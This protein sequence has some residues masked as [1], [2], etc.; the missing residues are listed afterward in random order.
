[1]DRYIQ[2][3]LMAAREAMD[4]AGLPDRLDGALAERTGA[5]LGT[6]LG[7]VGTL[8]EGFTTNAL[9]GAGRTGSARSW[10]RWASPT[11]ARGSSPSRSG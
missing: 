10:S 8:I 3:G 6:G 9:R 5:I 11:S 4:Q 7:G 1:M 2:F